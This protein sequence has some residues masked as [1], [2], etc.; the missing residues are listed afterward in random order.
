MAEPSHG[1]CILELVSMSA[2]AA[3]VI[4]DAPVFNALKR[5]IGITTMI[6][7]T[8]KCMKSNRDVALALPTHANVVKKCILERA[9]TER[10]AT[11]PNAEAL[12]AL[13]LALEN[14]HSYLTSL[15]TR[16][17]HMA[18]WV[19]ANQQKDRSAQLATAL[20]KVLALF[21]VR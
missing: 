18:S 11:A 4:C 17:G 16:R 15:K 1:E 8:A 19:L 10:E 9:S 21:T 14:I 7:D 12:E 6:C 3:G 13:K 2:L 5:V 20:D